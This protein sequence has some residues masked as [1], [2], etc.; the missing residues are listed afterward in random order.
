MSKVYVKGTDPLFVTQY[1][2]HEGIKPKNV[3]DSDF[4]L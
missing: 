3:F 1:L 4:F 2:E